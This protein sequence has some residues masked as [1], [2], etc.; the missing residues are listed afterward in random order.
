[1]N[2]HITIEIFAWESSPWFWSEK[3]TFLA[4]SSYKK[5]FLMKKLELNKRDNQMTFD[6]GN[7]IVNWNADEVTAP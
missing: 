2:G 5:S 7:V 6:Q 1:M 3:C 4:V